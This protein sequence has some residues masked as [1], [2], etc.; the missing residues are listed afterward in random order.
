[1]HEKHPPIL[2]KSWSLAIINCYGSDRAFWA[3]PAGSGAEPW[4]P[5]HFCG[6]VCRR[7]TSDDSYFECMCN[8]HDL[9]L[10]IIQG[11]LKHFQTL[12]RTF[13]FSS[14]FKGV[15]FF[16]TEFKYFQGFINTAMNPVDSRSD[17]PIN[18]MLY[19]YQPFCQQHL[20]NL[21]TRDQLLRS[22]YLLFTEVQ[23]NGTFITRLV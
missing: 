10:V 18:H 23:P 8:C 22:T 14:T 17:H 9:L 13:L 4:P 7:N 21:A 12:S 20:T 11:L 3:L 1:M 15:E 16:K 2:V 5:T 19:C 6:I